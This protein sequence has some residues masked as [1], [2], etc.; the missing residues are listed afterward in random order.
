MIVVNHMMDIVKEFKRLSNSIFHLKNEIVQKCGID[1]ACQ[2]ARLVALDSIQREMTITDMWITTLN[3][4]TNH[5]TDDNEF[6]ENGFLR[7]IGSIFNLKDTEI[8]MVDS[9]RLG[10]MV[11]VHFKIDNLFQNILRELNDLPEQR[12]YWNLSD[13]I[14][15]ISLIA[16]RGVEKDILTAFANLRNSLH[17]NGIHRTNDLEIMVDGLKFSF[18]KDEKVE[19]AS[20]QHILVALEANIDLLRKILLSNKIINL[21]NE[22]KDDFASTI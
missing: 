3:S 11:L 10:F 9:L 22:V 15:E 17:G 4:H 8:F 1:F 19:C 14:L 13:K 18:I 5:F 16:K 7:S 21:K 6:D 12:G 20:W 2:D